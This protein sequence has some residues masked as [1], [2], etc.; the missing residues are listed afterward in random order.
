MGRTAQ[1]VLGQPRLCGAGQDRLPAEILKDQII[2]WSISM[3]KGRRSPAIER[4][5]L[6]ESIMRHRWYE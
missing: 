2:R 1:Y 3:K 6:P 5:I 4:P